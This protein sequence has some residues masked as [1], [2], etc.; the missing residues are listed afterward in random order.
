M[1]AMIWSRAVTVRISCPAAP[2]NDTL[3]GD[4]GDDTLLGG[5]G[6]DQA[7]GGDGNDLIDTSGPI[8]LPDRGYP[9]LLSS[10][11]RS[12]E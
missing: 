1:P 5:D 9:G 3:D 10:G 8:S 6:R 11:Q 4:A 2:A 12:P 7:Y